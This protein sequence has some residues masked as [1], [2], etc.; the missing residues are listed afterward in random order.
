M[1]YHSVPTRVLSARPPA[2]RLPRVVSFLL[3]A[4]FLGACDDSDPAGEDNARSVCA[5]DATPG[6][7]EPL[8]VRAPPPATATGAVPHQQIGVQPVGSAIDALEDGVFALPKV[9]ARPSL[10]LFDAVA[11]WIREEVSI[12]RPECVLVGR[13]VG[14]IHSDGSIHVAVPHGRIPDA[15]SAGWIDP[16]PLNGIQP[17]FESYVLIF[18]P[19]S[20][21]EADVILEMVAEGVEFVTED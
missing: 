14:H 17:G 19:R 11:I 2:V 7:F 15:L 6:I 5:P 3:M 16:H 18:S 1:I 4:L 20:T 13:E 21:E 9:E 12:D 8:P 10:I